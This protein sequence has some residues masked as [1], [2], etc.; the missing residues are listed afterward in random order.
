MNI[1]YR[2]AALGAAAIAS[3][4]YAGLNFALDLTDAEGMPGETVQVS[5]LLDSFAP[6]D[7]WTFGALVD[8][9]AQITG[10]A[11]GADLA[12]LAPSFHESAFTANGLT[13]QTIVDFFGGTLPAG[14][15][16]ELVT[17]DVPIPL[18]AN[19]GDTY[20]IE[21]SDTIGSIG[22]PLTVFA[23]GVTHEPSTTGGTITVVPSSGA[24]ALF[25][26][27]GFASLRRKR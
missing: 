20:A 17:I 12:P 13:I 15:G 1:R 25:G 16:L 6:V 27:T 2:S 11:Q 10:S 4:S 3:Q 19:F 18:A 14:L 9:P 23:Q 21:F 22:V 5:V 24:F 7:G 8:L 26:L